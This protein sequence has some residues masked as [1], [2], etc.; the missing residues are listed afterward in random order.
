MASQEIKEDAAPKEEEKAD[1]PMFEK[2]ELSLPKQKK[3]LSGII[4]ELKY[5]VFLAYCETIHEKKKTLTKEQL[6]DPNEWQKT[7]DE[8]Q[9]KYDELR[10]K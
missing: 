8:L 10:Q 1:K 9:V 7:L 2:S 6:E 3:Y 5:H 4:D